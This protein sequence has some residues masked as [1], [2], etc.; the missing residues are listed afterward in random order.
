[1]R[2]GRGTTNSPTAQ[3]Y[4]L[5]TRLPP[6][7]RLLSMLTSDCT[8]VPQVLAIKAAEAITD[9]SAPFRQDRFCVCAFLRICV[10]ALP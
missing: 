9:I 6:H 3:Q 7:T 4:E 10:S 1:M 5:G 2:Y 8:P